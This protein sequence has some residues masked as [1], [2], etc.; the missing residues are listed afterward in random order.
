ML[1]ERSSTSEMVLVRESSVV[2]V[3]GGHEA[4]CSSRQN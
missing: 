4:S 3:G 1:V 2:V